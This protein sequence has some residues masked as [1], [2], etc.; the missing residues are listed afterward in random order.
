M[1]GRNVIK[2]LSLINELQTKGLE[3]KILNLEVDTQKA[4]VRLFLTM[5][6]KICRV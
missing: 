6:A 4:S 3:I 2:V 1:N 5:S